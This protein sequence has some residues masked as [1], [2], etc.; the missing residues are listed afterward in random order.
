MYASS[1]INLA[2]SNA[3]SLRAFSSTSRGL[4]RRQ[5]FVELLSDVPR[6]GKSFDRLFVAPGRA[7]NDLVPNRKAR[8]IPFKNSLHRQELK[9]TDEERSNHFLRIESPDA[10]AIYQRQTPETPQPTPQHLLDAL[11]ILP[12]TIVFPLRTVSPSSS[13]L[14]GSLNLSDVHQVLAQEHNLDSTEVEVF[15]AD[16]EPGARIKEIG[17]WRAIIKLRKGGEEQ[18]QLQ[19]QVVRQD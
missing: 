4:A 2:R 8:F 17:T 5:A 11:H 14:H 19:I 3:A 10:T 7:R 6:L 15:W 18:V 12:D 1:S 16:H 9:M 13:T